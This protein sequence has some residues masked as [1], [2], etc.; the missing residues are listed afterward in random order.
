MHYV[1][2]DGKTVYKFAVKNMNKQQRLRKTKDA[3]LAAMDT[4]DT[5]QLIQSKDKEE[6]VN[7]GE[8]LWLKDKKKII[9]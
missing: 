1:Y 7:E 2:Q 9:H 5:A 3:T 4:M 6:K 8:P